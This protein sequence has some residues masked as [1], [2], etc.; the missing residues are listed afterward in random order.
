MEFSCKGH[1]N[2]ALKKM[3]ILF[4]PKKK[5]FCN[6]LYFVEHTMCSMS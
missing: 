5:K 6:N 4:K 3:S 2:L 1:L